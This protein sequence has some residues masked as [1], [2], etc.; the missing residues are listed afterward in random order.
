M[1]VAVKINTES[2]VSAVP[3]LLRPLYRLS[4]EQYERMAEA[5]ILKDKDRVELLEGFLVEKMTRNPPHNSAGDHAAELLRS[6]LPPEWRVRE[7]KAIRLSRSVPEPD[8]SVVE[9]P[10]SRYARRHPV[11]QDIALVIEI[12]QSSL[13]EDR[14]YMGGVYAQ[15]RIP[16]Y[17]IINL[18][19]RQIEVYSQ[20]KGGKN[21]AYQSGM[22]TAQTKQCP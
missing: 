12:A 14:E 19:E 3:P 20:P 5:G 2:P 11:P 13:K 21:A 6:I 7:Q 22:I 4:V 8:V 18:V 17:W 10:L 9:G 15:A 1:S 16:V